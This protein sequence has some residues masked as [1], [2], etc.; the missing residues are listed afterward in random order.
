[1]YVLNTI[2]KKSKYYIA[3]IQWPVI[4]ETIIT[5]PIPAHLP[6]IEEYNL[7]SRTRPVSQ[8]RPYNDLT[9]AKK[10]QEPSQLKKGSFQSRNR[11]FGKKKSI[12]NRPKDLPAG[13]TMIKFL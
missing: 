12:N 6:D 11:S 10:L 5:S 13:V 3:P 9:I 7:L 4:T 8:Q 1:M 2:A